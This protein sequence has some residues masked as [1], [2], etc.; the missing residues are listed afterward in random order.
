MHGV[1]LIDF[2]ETRE[3][4]AKHQF[5]CDFQVNSANMPDNSRMRFH[6]ENWS[7]SKIWYQITTFW[8]TQEINGTR[9]YWWISIRYCSRRTIIYLDEVSVIDFGWSREKPRQKVCKC[10]YIWNRVL[11]VQ[12]IFDIKWY[13]SRHFEYVLLFLREL[14]I[15]VH[16]SKVVRLFCLKCGPGPNDAEEPWE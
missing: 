8:I 6:R 3:T 1:H 16:E 9:W 7:H 15:E 12:W 13:K 5:S 10:W 2:P 11:K 4:V 14:F